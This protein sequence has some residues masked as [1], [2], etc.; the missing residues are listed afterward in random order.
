M[1]PKYQRN[2][3]E[4]FAAC[5]ASLMHCPVSAVPVLNELPG[6]RLPKGYE[7]KLNH[8]LL[9]KECGGYVE[10]GFKENLPDLLDGMAEIAPIAWYILIGLNKANAT[11]S[12]VCQGGTIRHDP[13][14]EPGQHTL[15]GPCDDGHFRVGLLLYRPFST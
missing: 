12:V 9:G 1:I 15:V 10:F 2:Q 4:C 5:I 8:W 6:E 3:R 14:A 13:S 7:T 11:H